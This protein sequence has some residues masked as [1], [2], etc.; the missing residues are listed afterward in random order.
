MKWHDH[1]SISEK[2]CQGANRP[3]T[4]WDWFWLFVV[5]VNLFALALTACRCLGWP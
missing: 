3:A 1:H 5:I 4:D 2:K